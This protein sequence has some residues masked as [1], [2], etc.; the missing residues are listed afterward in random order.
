MERFTRKQRSLVLLGPLGAL[1]VSAI[2]WPLLGTAALLL[3]PILIGALIIWVLVDL[4]H[5]QWDL[6]H[7]G[8]L[9]QRAI[10]GQLEAMVGLNAVLG[11][12]YPFPGTRG[13]A[14]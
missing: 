13:W 2:A 11:P 4:R 10:Y 7:R 5:H 6:F 8:V 12:K 14:A 9:E 3:P 1:L